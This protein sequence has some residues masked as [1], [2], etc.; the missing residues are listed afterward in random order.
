MNKLLEPLERHYAPL[1]TRERVLIWL[2]CL[3]LL[4]LPAY[5]WVAEPLWNQ[6]KQ[7]QQK[8]KQLVVDNQTAELQIL[9]VRKKLKADPNASLLTQKANLEKQLAQADQAIFEQQAGL[10]P[11]ERMAGVLEQ[12]L[13]KSGG[14]TL[15][16]MTSLAPEPVLSAEE[17]QGEGVDFHRH[18]IRLTLEGRYLKVLQYLQVVEAFPTRFL[19]HSLDYQVLTYPKARVVV[20]LYSLGSSKDFISG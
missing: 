9:A 11:V 8:Q 12:L 5:V 18:G 13:A 1:K 6:L 7:Q 14:L 20:E 2:A 3:T 4:L 19:W 16:E 10:I 15:I 17:T